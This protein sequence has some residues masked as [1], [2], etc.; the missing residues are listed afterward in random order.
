MCKDL[1]TQAQDYAEKAILRLRET[2]IATEDTV[3]SAIAEAYKQGYKDALTI[4]SN[5]DDKQV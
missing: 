1:E 2:I 4:K 5:K 3:F